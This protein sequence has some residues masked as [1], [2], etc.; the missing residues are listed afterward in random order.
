M[1]AGAEAVETASRMRSGG[2][3]DLAGAQAASADA[4]PLDAAVHQGADAL[5][6]RLEPARCD[7]VRVADVPADDRPFSADFAAF[8]HGLVIVG[9]A[10]GRL[11]AAGRSAGDFAE[12]RSPRRN[13]WAA[14]QTSDYTPSALG[15]Q[16][17]DTFVPAVG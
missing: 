6:V 3:D 2:L 1:A 11:S 13:G 12:R 8:C 14:A 5:E 10:R 9:N 7:I 16:P 17:A 15:G 4:Q